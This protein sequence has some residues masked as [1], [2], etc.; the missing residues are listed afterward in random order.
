MACKGDTL[1]THASVGATCWD[2]T[3]LHV[4]INMS[5][6]SARRVTLVKIYLRRGP[7]SPDQFGKMQKKA[8]RQWESRP[9][10]YPKSAQ[11]KLKQQH[12]VPQNNSS[13]KCHSGGGHFE[14]G[15]LKCIESAR[16]ESIC[17]RCSKT[18]DYCL[19]FSCCYRRRGLI[20]GSANTYKTNACHIFYR[21]GSPQVGALFCRW[22][23][24]IENHDGL[25][26]ADRG[27]VYVLPG[28]NKRLMSGRELYSCCYEAQSSGPQIAED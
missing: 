21:Q 9:G 28:W 1:C 13:C 7:P 5:S 4:Q 2:N 16:V 17:P 11:N 25:H 10:S 3:D 18:W 12:I 15:C 14:P 8:V 22:S 23:S 26:S 19:T 27:R 6:P 20:N 24:E